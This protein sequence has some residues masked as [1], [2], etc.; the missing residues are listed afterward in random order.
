M[1]IFG[2]CVL[3]LVFVDELLA[4]AA[5]ATWG[6]YQAGAWFAVLVAVLTTLGWYLFASPKARF[7]GRLA[8]PL[9]KVI[10]FTL[11]SIG[12]WVSGHHDLGIAYFAFS[13]VINATAQLP[14][15][16]ALVTDY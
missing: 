15:I 14:S 5:A 3:F 4:I 12:L 7:G 16:S 10:V 9:G 1:A 11:A 8:R 2:W 13:V 6:D